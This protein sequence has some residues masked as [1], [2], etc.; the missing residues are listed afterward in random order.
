MLSPLLLAPPSF[1]IRILLYARS[2]CV[3]RILAQAFD[4]SSRFKFIWPFKPFYNLHVWIGLQAI[5]FLPFHQ[6][7][8]V[9]VGDDLIGDWVFNFCLN[10]SSEGSLLKIKLAI[11]N[12]RIFVHLWRPLNISIIFSSDLNRKIL[13]L[14]WILV[15]V[16]GNQLS[17]WRV[18]LFLLVFF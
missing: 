17:D 7:S 4:V 10:I 2:P 5:L 9:V 15:H 12:S 14:E 16:V 3:A 11:I 13:L 8:N 1:V 18:F 6:W